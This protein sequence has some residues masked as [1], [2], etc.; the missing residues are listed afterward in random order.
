MAKTDT[1]ILIVYANT[2]LATLNTRNYLRKLVMPSEPNV[3]IDDGF[4]TVPLRFR[5]NVP[6]HQ[7]PSEP[8]L[9]MVQAITKEPKVISVSSN[10]EGNG[11]SIHVSEKPELQLPHPYSQV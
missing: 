4:N 3:N 2:L 1:G 6:G 8:D 11:P 5:V 7:F 9:D 10:A